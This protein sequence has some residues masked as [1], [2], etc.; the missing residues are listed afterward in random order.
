MGDVQKSET[1]QS[2][3]LKTWAE[4]PSQKYTRVEKGGKFSII[5]DKKQKTRA[6][7]VLRVFENVNKKLAEDSSLKPQDLNT[8]KRKCTQMLDASLGKKGTWKRT[9]YSIIYSKVEKEFQK[10]EQNTL[11]QATI[12]ELS[13]ALKKTDYIKYFANAKRSMLT[14]KQT[15]NFTLPNKNEVSIEFTI[16]GPRV[17]IREKN[18][19]T[20]TILDP[21]NAKKIIDFVLI[22]PEDARTKVLTQLTPMSPKD[23]NKLK[24]TPKE[25]E[26]RVLEIETDDGRKWA[27]CHKDADFDPRRP[28]YKLI[29]LDQN[30]NILARPEVN[31]SQ[32][33]RGLEFDYIESENI[34]N[35]IPLTST[36][37]RR[38]DA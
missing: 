27:I 7:T 4:L 5:T 35:L 16:K 18:K 11:T 34:R 32:L 23:I 30:G 25:P 15:V 37:K 26:F 17:S 19:E 22:T 10:I 20:I 13:T 2:S 33:E 28:L 29:Q 14:P 8:V 36:V 21:E 12:Q 24:V 9:I 1:P 3:E 6:D 31:F 38:P